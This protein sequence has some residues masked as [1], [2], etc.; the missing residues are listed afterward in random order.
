MQFMKSMQTDGILGPQGRKLQHALFTI[1]HMVKQLQDH[2][3][4]EYGSKRY[5]KAL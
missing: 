3:L 4:Y 5:T 1:V 2:D